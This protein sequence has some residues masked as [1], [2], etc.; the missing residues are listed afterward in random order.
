MGKEKASAD[1]TINTIRRKT[2]RKHSAE[3][4]ICIVLWGCGERTASP[5]CVVGKALYRAFELPP[6]S[7]TEEKT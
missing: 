1:Q 7:R 4:K 5:N 2:Q 3:E 6:I